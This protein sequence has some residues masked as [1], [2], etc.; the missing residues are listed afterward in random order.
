MQ[1]FSETCILSAA[2]ELASKA[3]DSLMR[4]LLGIWVAIVVLSMA[5]SPASATPGWRS[6]KPVLARKAMIVTAQHLATKVGLGILRK[7]GNAVDAAVAIGYALAVVHPCCGNLGGGGFMTIHLAGGKNIFLDF[8]EKAPLEATRTMYLSP[9]GRVNHRESLWSW[10]AIAVPGTVMGLDAALSRYGTMTR[11]EVMAPAIRLARDGYILNN[12]DVALIH[13]DQKRLDKDAVTHEV[14]SENGEPLR[15]GKRFRQPALAHS[16]ELIEKEGAKAFYRGPIGRSIVRASRQHGG[17]LTMKDLKDYQVVWQRPIE[18]NYRGY[19]IVSAPPPSSGGVTVCEILNVLSGWPRYS[20]YK[21]HSAKAVHDVVEAMRFAFADRNT[22]LGDPKFVNN[23]IKKLL[24]A[25]HAAW[26]R[27]QIPQDRAVPSI[28]VHGSLAADEGHDTTQ[29]SIVDKQG[30]AVS[31][32]YTLNSLFGTGLMAP[33]TGIL[34]NNEMNDFTA[35]PGVP[36]QF[37]LVQGK[38]NDIA[39]GKRPLSSMTPTIVLKNGR[40]ALVTGSPGGS[41]IITTT[42]EVILNVVDR[43]MNIAQAVD[44]PRV[45]QQWLPDV[46]FYEPGAFT[47]TVTRRLRKMGYHLA[48]RPPWGH[49]PATW[50][51]AESIRVRSN[52]ILAGAN[53]ARRPSGLALGYPEVK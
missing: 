21:F 42:L 43:G 50:G 49:G 7:G 16:L 40:V 14:F 10:K 32:T 41:T 19:T 23:P 33:K 30:N 18:C 27:S 53:D 12:A 38:A 37:G 26:I 35:K 47:P 36:N 46:V 24:S 4:F 29:Y 6:A 15:A 3:R 1:N 39:P 31:V 20:T 48:E 44:A 9:S 45:H 8:R 22:Y 11:A 52:G 13:G 5:V 2:R 25:G 34:L 17:I 28:Q 51:A